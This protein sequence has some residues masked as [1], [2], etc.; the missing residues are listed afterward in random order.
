[1]YG[2]KSGLEAA[3]AAAAKVDASLHAKGKL[4]KNVSF[5]EN[6]DGKSLQYN[7]IN[8]FSCFV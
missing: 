2:Q 8:S 5:T 7:N 3:V 1:M 6:V 4:T